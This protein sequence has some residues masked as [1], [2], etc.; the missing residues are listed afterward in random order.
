[1]GDAVVLRG[2]SYLLPWGDA[3]DA[4]GATSPTRADK[5]YF[6]D[7]DGGSST[8]TLTSQ[9]AGNSAF[10]L[11]RLTDQGRAKVADVTAHD[12]TVTLTGDKATPYVL[13]P[14]G[15]ARAVPAAGYGAGSGVVDPGFNAGTLDQWG[16]RGK[17]R[18]H[19]AYAE[20]RNTSGLCNFYQGRRQR[21]L[22]DC[23]IGPVNGF[24]MES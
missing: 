16:H 1:M 21:E 22:R 12:A 6:Y 18:H 7:A 2:G 8:F 15:A 9:F 10:T 11:Y 19:R 23:R 14:K 3:K 13:V 5:M 4:D 17:L 20:L 24:E